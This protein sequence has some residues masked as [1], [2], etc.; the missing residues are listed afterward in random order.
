MGVVIEM[1]LMLQP[2]ECGEHH[3]A[4]SASA[5]LDLPPSKRSCASRSAMVPEVAVGLHGTQIEEPNF[6]DWAE[7]YLTKDIPLKSHF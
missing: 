3:A 1:V 5:R 6:L 7:F 4:G 2:H